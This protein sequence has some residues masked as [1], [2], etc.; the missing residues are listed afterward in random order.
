MG[1]PGWDSYDPSTIDWVGFE[2]SD[3][4]APVELVASLLRGDLPPKAIVRIEAPARTRR[5]FER[6]H[7]PV[8][9]QVIAGRPA[10]PL[11]IHVGEETAEP[12]AAR[13]ARLG[14]E[15]PSGW[16]FASSTGTFPWVE[17]VSSVS[18]EEIV[19][20]VV[21]ALEAMGEKDGEWRAGAALPV[22]IEHAHGPFGTH[23]HGPG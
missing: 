8:A 13:F 1:D 18:A 23:T 6:R 21:S 4:A 15:L 5:W 10:T 17:P 9:A 20:F 12:V 2:R 22:T 14:V 19:R 11:I 3:L 7:P 16:T